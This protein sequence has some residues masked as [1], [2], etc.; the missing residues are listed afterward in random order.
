MT[1]NIKKTTHTVHEKFNQGFCREKKQGWELTWIH[2]LRSRKSDNLQ[3]NKPIPSKP[4]WW[5]LAGSWALWGTFFFYCSC[6]WALL[7]PCGIGVTS[8]WLKP[9]S[10]SFRLS[11]FNQWTV[12]L[13]DT[14]WSFY[15]LF[16]HLDFNNLWSWKRS[17]NTD[18]IEPFWKC[19]PKTDYLVGP[20]GWR[21]C[22]VSHI[23]LFPAFF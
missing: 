23:G 6:S 1:T 3:I 16:R 22:V 13:T 19:P 5:T 20:V 15:I 10:T 12:N 8:I 11:P 7:H 9:R 17:C 18:V 2:G 14:L 21:P 4:L